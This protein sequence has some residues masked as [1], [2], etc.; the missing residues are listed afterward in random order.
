MEPGML[1][2]IT[3]QDIDCIRRQLNN[4]VVLNNKMIQRVEV[5]PHWLY[6]Y[7]ASSLDHQV[8]ER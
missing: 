7:Q 5:G 3:R 2:E 6:K 4:F 1:E 8:L